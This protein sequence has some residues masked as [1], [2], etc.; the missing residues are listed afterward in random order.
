VFANIVVDTTW[1][2]R[3]PVATT[4]MFVL[5]LAVVVWYNNREES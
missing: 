2:A 1:V 5:V 4:V 3:H